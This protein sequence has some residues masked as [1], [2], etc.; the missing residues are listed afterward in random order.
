MEDTTVRIPVTVTK[1]P[2]RK[3]GW[4]A[5]YGR[6]PYGI[7]TREAT[8]GE[9]KAALAAAIMT[10][11]SVHQQRPRFARDDDGAVWAAIPAADGGS[12]W[13]RITNDTA[14]L[15]TMASAPAADAFTSC[16]GMTVIPGP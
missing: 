3:A 2:G 9:A 13:Y 14:R 7:E 6:Y 11:A 15:N 10:A 4:L 12:T 5:E 1:L 8:A 16:V